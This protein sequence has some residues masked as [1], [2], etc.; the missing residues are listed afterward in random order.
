MS[1]G[2]ENGEV[3][4][5][6]EYMECDFSKLSVSPRVRKMIFILVRSQ[7]EIELSA[8]GWFEL[9]FSGPKVRG[10]LKRHMGAMR[11]D[12]DLT[13]TRKRVYPRN[14]R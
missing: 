10:S 5:T 6:Q 14:A 1:N 12:E 13:A 7:D 3:D 4:L 2:D 9:H 8:Q 11:V